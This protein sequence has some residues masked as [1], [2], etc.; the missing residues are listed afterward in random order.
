MKR[1]LK[2]ALLAWEGLQ[3][4]DKAFSL[5]TMMAIGFSRRAYQCLC[6]ISRRDMMYTLSLRGSIAVEMRCASS[7]TASIAIDESRESDEVDGR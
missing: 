1:L 4:S 2:S 5:W 3:S 7:R 6:A